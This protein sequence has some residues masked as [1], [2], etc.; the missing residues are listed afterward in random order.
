VLAAE[1][2]TAGLSRRTLLI[3]HSN[4]ARIIQHLDYSYGQHFYRF[5]NTERQTAKSATP[6]P[7]SEID[8]QRHPERAIGES[9][10]LISNLKSSFPLNLQ[11][12][13]ANADI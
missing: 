2:E 10:D 6:T 8:A 1:D 4:S 5:Y 11:L 7:Q 13:R 12:V 3:T 9:K